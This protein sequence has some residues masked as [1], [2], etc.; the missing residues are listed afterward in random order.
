[1]GG[2]VAYRVFIRNPVGDNGGGG[3]DVEEGPLKNAQSMELSMCFVV[4]GG[5]CFFVGS[6]FDELTTL[7]SSKMG[8]PKTPKK[9]QLSGSQVE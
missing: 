4:W 1:M 8:T 9:S 2:W 6:V 3:G 7:D 5:V